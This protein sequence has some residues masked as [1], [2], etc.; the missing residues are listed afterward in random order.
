MMAMDPVKSYGL[1]Q[2]PIF[3]P[4]TFLFLDK[5]GVF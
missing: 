1:T 4:L 2:G 3:F 5:I